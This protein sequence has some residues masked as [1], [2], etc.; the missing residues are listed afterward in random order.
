VADHLDADC[1]ARQLPL[2]CVVDEEQC[3][4]RDYVGGDALGPW[5]RMTRED[6]GHVEAGDVRA[7]GVMGD[8]PDELVLP[9]VR[10]LAGTAP[11][12]PSP[13]DQACDAAVY[14]DPSLSDAD[15]ELAL[16]LIEGRVTRS[17][18]PRGIR[19]AADRAVARLRRADR[20]FVAQRK[21]SHQARSVAR[22]EGARPRP[23]AR[24]RARTRRN[25]AG[26]AS[27]DAPDADADLQT[28]PNHAGL[29]LRT[30][31]RLAYSAV[32]KPVPMPAGGDGV[33]EQVARL[34]ARLALPGDGDGEG[35]KA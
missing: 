4:V 31:G 24:A 11:S 20:R 15:S 6:W 5:R 1:N 2:V 28:A 13:R 8:L 16:Q 33:R 26:P 10:R 21:G 23:R 3:R 34:L 19:A 14:L 18:V 17:V 32:Y 12:P 9:E 7:F 29:A 25:R 22:P 30:T 27:A 35:P